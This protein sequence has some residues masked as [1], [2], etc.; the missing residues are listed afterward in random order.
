V[1][2]ALLTAFAERRHAKRAYAAAAT[3]K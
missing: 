1:V 2:S 3:R